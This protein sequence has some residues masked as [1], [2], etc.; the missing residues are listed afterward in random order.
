MSF[1]EDDKK[2]D[3]NFG[4]T[5]LVYPPTVELDTTLTV[6]GKAADAKATGD[7]IA[8]INDQLA[9]LKEGG[10][11]PVD[12]Q[13]NG[14]SIVES[15][16]ANIP[17]A[18]H[19]KV[20]VLKIGGVS[21]GLYIGANGVLTLSP[22]S[23]SDIAEK[24]NTYKPLSPK[25]LDYA[26]KV[27]LTT[28]TE[29][30]TDAEKESACEWLSVVRKQPY[31][32]EI[33]KIEGSDGTYSGLVYGVGFGE[34]GQAMFPLSAQAYIWTIPIRNGNG[35]FYVSSPVL[36]YECAN[37]KYVDDLIQALTDRIV[38]LETQLSNMK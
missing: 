12:V 6:E 2:I 27:G 17:L 30:L 16:V 5:H 15:G 20:G 36:G 28:N 38:E 11:N 31:T 18:A 7:K 37:K 1:N 13:I 32:R 21:Y 34:K 4:S 9:E 3:V 14:T 26:I 29:T 25:H 19:D 33:N 8:E 10:G 35:N 23:Q 24:T 22:A